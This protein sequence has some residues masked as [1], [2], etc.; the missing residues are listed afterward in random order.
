A[1]KEGWEKRQKS[2]VKGITYEYNLSSLPVA[3]KATILSGIFEERR[4]LTEEEV[5][6]EK[7]TTQELSSDYPEGLDFQ[8][9]FALIPGYRIQVSAGHGAINGAQETPCRYLAFRRK[10]LTHKGFCQK[11]LTVVW[12]KG[13]SM[14]PTINDN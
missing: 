1:T 12:A 13:D 6:T 4:N 10:W 11:D 14:H 5:E 8:K 7:L 9:E 2:G 3:T